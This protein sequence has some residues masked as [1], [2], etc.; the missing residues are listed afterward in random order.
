M[1]KAILILILSLSV[2]LQLSKA[3]IV[4]SEFMLDDTND[5]DIEKITFKMFNWKPYAVNT[6]YDEVTFRTEITDKDPINKCRISY[7]TS[8]QRFK[9]SYDFLYEALHS[10]LEKCLEAMI[11]MKY[12]DIKDFDE[13][14]FEYDIEYLEFGPLQPN[15]ACE[16]KNLLFLTRGDWFNIVPCPKN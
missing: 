10:D 9:C 15:I 4:G 6:N 12:P 8:R 7:D 5:D 14:V 1:S 16:I 2:F 11:L 13:Y 3:D